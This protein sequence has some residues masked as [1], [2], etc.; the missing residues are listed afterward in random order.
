MKKKILFIIT[1]DLFVRNYV[2]SGVLR[3]LSRN[4]DVQ[5]LF[6][7][8]V[9]Q[10]EKIPGDLGNLHVYEPAPEREK[11][12]RLC[13]DVLMVKYSSKSTSFRFRVRRFFLPLKSFTRGARNPVRFLWRMR[14]Y[15]VSRVKKFKLF[16]LASPLAFPFY[17]YFVI[18]RAGVN[19]S[20]KKS[21][22]AVEPDLVLLPSAAYESDA[23]DLIR[24]C[25]KHGIKTL[26]LI[27]NW[28]N[29][30]SKSIL[31]ERPDHLGV[32]GEQSLS[33]AV[34][35]QN[36]RTENL[37][38][39]G[40]PRFDHYFRVRDSKPASHFSFEYVLFVGCALQFDEIG[41]LAAMD[42]ELE[43]APNRFGDLKIV[44]R[45]HP[46]GFAK[47]RLAEMGFKRVVVD[48]QISE[49]YSAGL[50]GSTDLQPSLDYYPGLL[51]NAR[52][53]VGGISSMLI[54]SMI[55]RKPYLV[56]AY[57]EQDN[58]TSPKN[59]LDNYVHFRGLEGVE[60][61]YFCRQQTDLPAKLVNL[62]ETPPLFKNEKL[63]EQR[64]FFLYSDARPYGKR[65][66]DLVS[67]ILA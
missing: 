50:A 10:R 43:K 8:D 13:Y 31:W 64:Q 7:S 44:Y 40:T 2:T 36:F 3:E 33:H 56:L 25:R 54:E 35:I 53:V 59:I 24:I 27:D 28:D 48:P 11:A 26:F 23:I 67:G 34:E 17:K 14:P 6:R 38:T 29:L 61:V 18:D 62:L 47:N 37:T 22:L 52:L 60:S 42:R 5:L 20:L 1:S 16:F 66:H 58:L 19:A 15:L 55:F 65:L 41:A 45:P 30:S 46:W 51:A 63:D 57:D 49:A 9:T 39:I 12:A 32:W 4:Y 21:V